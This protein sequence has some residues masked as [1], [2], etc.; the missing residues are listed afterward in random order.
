MRAGRSTLNNAQ[1]LIAPRLAVQGGTAN[2]LLR[3]VFL[4][5][6]CGDS[7]VEKWV[8]LL[9]TPSLLYIILV[10]LIRLL[11]FEYGAGLQRWIFAI[12]AIL[13]LWFL[14]AQDWRLLRDC[15]SGWELIIILS[16]GRCFTLALMLQREQDH[17]IGILNTTL[18]RPSRCHCL[19]KKLI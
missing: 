6:S 1:P 5:L 12:R 8:H 11:S 10:S 3:I 13:V 18:L 7:W 17:W 2:N 14:L 9:L 15:R 19:L 4:I 16:T